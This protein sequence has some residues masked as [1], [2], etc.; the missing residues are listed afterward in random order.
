MGKKEK[1]TLY[2]NEKSNRQAHELAQLLGK[3]V[4]ELVREYTVELSQKLKV[5]KIS[6]GVSKWVGI[7]KTNKSYKQLRDEYIKARLKRYEDLA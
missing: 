1:L 3:S 5:K 6:P 7:L 2:M 4:S